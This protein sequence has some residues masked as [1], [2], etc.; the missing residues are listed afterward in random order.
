MMKKITLFF[1]LLIGSFGYSQTLPIDF[2]TATTW[3]DFDGGVVTTETNSFSN[4]D[5][6]SANVGKMVKDV[7]Q[8]WGGSSITLSTANGFRKQ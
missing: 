8:V 2:E 3:T 5:N 4:A 7:G 1:V 6:N